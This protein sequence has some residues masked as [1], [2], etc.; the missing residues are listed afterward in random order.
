M[1]DVSDDALTSIIEDDLG[2][3]GVEMASCHAEVAEYDLDALTTAGRYRVHG[4]ARHAGGVSPYSF[5]VKVVQSWT[6]SP[7]FEQVPEAFRDIAAASLPWRNEPAVYRSDLRDR[8]PDGFS[9]PRAYSVVDIDE[10]SAGLWLQFIDHDSSRWGIDTFARAAYLLGR[11][12]ASPTVRPLRTL[13]STD[14]VRGYDRGRLEHQV[15]PVLRSEELWVHPLVAGAF[16]P[17]LRHRILDAA[18]AL[19]R[20]LEELDGAP[21]GS[22]H[23]DAC[24]RNLLATSGNQETLV[25]ID[26]GFWCEAPLSFDLTQLMVGEIQTGERPA[27]ELPDL[28]GVCL[29]AYHRGLIDEG[30]TVSLDAL[31]R[32]HA[33][34]M[35]LFYGLS[36]VPL[37]VLFGLPA[38]GSADVVRERA[39]AASFVLDLLD[40]T[41]GP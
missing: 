39:R 8:L 36:A 29:P 6:R 38:P 7:Q 24:P 16:D 15:L 10:L 14:V 19:P 34:L 31:R 9:M 25:L 26:F 1:A 21:L 37:E 41:R 13:G 3:R 33:L 18:E 5:F 40:S 22:A 23:G 2:V 27:S 20:F 12:A 35:V 30:C 28:E 4:T 11:L 17:D 32:T